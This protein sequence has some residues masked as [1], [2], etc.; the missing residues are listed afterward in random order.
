M[1]KRIVSQA[2][3]HGSLTYKV[4]SKAYI[5]RIG[6][7]PLNTKGVVK[8]DKLIN[9]MA[10]SAPIA[11]LNVVGK[12]YYIPAAQGIYEGQEIEVEPDEG[13]IKI[14]NIIS[15][16]KIPIGTEVFNIETR[17]G[18]GGKMIRTSGGFATVLK[19]D[20]E[21]IVLAMTNK[22]EV[23]LNGNCRATIGVIAGQGRVIKP[24]IK[25]GKHHYMMGA[26]NKK[27]HLTSKVKVNA[28]D[29]PFGGGRG[30][31]IKSKIA[32]RNAPPGARVGHI[33]PKR[34]GRKSGS[35]AGN[36]GSE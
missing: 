2:R 10:H 19:K 14:G 22:R 3:G 18:D 15:L 26:R 23:A 7:P 32:K 33:S 35:G 11:K 9:S 36:G 8:I 24:I 13:R 25:A 16:K 34:T 28:V 27:W 4:R 30:K 20:N 6:Y 21:K 17:P 5:Y 1:G 29:H 31:R 12:S